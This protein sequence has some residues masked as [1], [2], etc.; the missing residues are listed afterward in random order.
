MSGQF[1][2]YR[3]GECGLVVEVL[4]RSA[5]AKAQGARL[6]CCGQAMSRQSENP[7]NTAEADKHVPVI[8]RHEGNVRV[9]V[10]GGQHPMQ[11][12]HYIDWIEVVEGGRVHRRYLR[13]G[14]PPEAVFQIGGEMF[15]VRN[16]CVRHGLWQMGNP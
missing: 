10:A 4:S 16:H 5:R 9:S 14:E 13:P 15:T 12:N 3:C 7:D 6:S 11:P 2:I 1:D 8:E